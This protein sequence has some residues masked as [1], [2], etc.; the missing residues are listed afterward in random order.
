MSDGERKTER[1]RVCV[2]CAK[3]LPSRP[4]LNIDE[5]T[6]AG[7]EEDVHLPAGHCF[8]TKVLWEQNGLECGHTLGVETQV[9]GEE[10]LAPT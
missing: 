6:F 10:A 1:E 8:G 5:A 4:R 3:R 7:G 9:A 2:E